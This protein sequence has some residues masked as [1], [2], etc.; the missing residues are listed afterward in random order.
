MVRIEPRY[1]REQ[2]HA[3]GPAVIAAIT[4]NDGRIVGRQ[5]KPLTADLSAKD[6]VE[7]KTKNGA[8]DKVKGYAIRLG[9]PRETLYLAEGLED[10]MTVMQAFDMSVTAFAMGGAGMMEGFIPPRSQ[11]HKADSFFGRCVIQAP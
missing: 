5:Y 7:P 6:G 8:G 11:T 3:W 4:D 10:A 1:R 9:P 2:T